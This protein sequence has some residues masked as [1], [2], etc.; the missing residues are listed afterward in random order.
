MADNF[1]LGGLASGMDTNALIE[2]LMKIESN[3][4]TVAQNRQAAFQSQISQ[5]GEITSKLQALAA[6]TAALKTN[7]ALGLSQVGTHSGATV[8]LGPTAAAGQY[9]LGVDQLATTAKAQSVAFP[10]ADSPVHG[11]LSLSVDGVDTPIPMTDGMSLSEVAAAINQSGAKVRATIIQTDG[12][13]FLQIATKNT[14]F[15]PGQ[16]T[17]SALVITESSSGG[18][19]LPLGFTITQ[20][21]TNALVTVEGVQLERSSNTIADAVP[22]VTLALKAVTAAPEDVV[23]GTD[24]AATAT[25]LQTF[26][27]AYN[28][29]MALIHKNLNIGQEVDRTKTLGGDSALRG[30]QNSLM[31][32]V[33]SIANPSSTTLRS[34]LDLGISTQKDG[35]LGL[36]K[37]KMDKA[38]S[39]D[40]DAVNALFQQATDGVSDRIKSLVDSYTNSSDGILVSKSKSYDKSVKQISTEIDSLRLRIEAR[41]TQLISQFAAMEKMVGGFKSIGNYL[42]SQETKNKE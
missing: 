8:T 18:L 35:T 29:V 26:V 1:R 30:L 38:L 15:T 22:G 34:L 5:V 28:D 20:Q 27:T 37:S 32:M 9:A 2:Q 31:G 7:G 33:S 42:T 11:T 36:D 19:P 25:K 17:S 40:P 4:I 39:A 10:S 41:R 16:P 12:Q 6:A 23:L 21:A 13:A 14:G 24:S 3:S